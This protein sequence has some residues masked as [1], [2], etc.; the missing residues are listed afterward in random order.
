MI[1]Y[2]AQLVTPYDGSGWVVDDMLLL[3]NSGSGLF[4]VEIVRVVERVGKMA[5]N[6]CQFV[7]GRPLGRA[8]SGGAGTSVFA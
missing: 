5:P 1:D 3:G 8:A 4:V 6:G 7:D 2:D